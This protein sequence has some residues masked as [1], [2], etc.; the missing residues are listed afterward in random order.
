MRVRLYTH[1]YE[2]LVTCPWHLF[3]AAQEVDW[4]SQ[5][6]RAKEV[7]TEHAPMIQAQL[8][9]AKAVVAEAATN[10]AAVLEAKAKMAE[11]Q[12][13]TPEVPE[14]KPQIYKAPPEVTTASKEPELT[15][16]P[17]APQLVAAPEG[18]PQLVEA[19]TL[20]PLSKKKI[21]DLNE[22]HN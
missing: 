17:E 20:I 21:I 14:M 8:A 15:E 11:V 9:Q 6:R 16:L 13:A 12:P 2:V 19:P 18:P 1:C 22:I 5:V 3:L 7:V 10:A 4:T